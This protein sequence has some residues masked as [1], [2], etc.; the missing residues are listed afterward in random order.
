MRRTIGN[1][2]G[3]LH[4][5]EIVLKAP[6]KQ[7]HWITSMCCHSFQLEIVQVHER[8]GTLSSPEGL[9]VQ[10]SLKDLKRCDFSLCFR[11]CQSAGSPRIHP[12]C[13][14]KETMEAFEAI[15]SGESHGKAL[16]IRWLCIVH[17]TL[18]GTLWQGLGDTSSTCS[19]GKQR[20]LGGCSCQKLAEIPAERNMFRTSKKGQTNFPHYL[21][22]LFNWFSTIYSYVQEGMY[23]QSAG[24]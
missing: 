13:P 5:F 4:A 17:T 3:A 7:I 19:A 18:N 12:S 20:R 2:A 21:R 15:K 6:L 9:H 11:L 14:S 16:L 8:L 22:N 23:L 10:N 24:R 1:V